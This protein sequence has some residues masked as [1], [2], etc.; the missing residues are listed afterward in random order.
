MTTMLLFYILHKNFPNTICIVT[1]QSFRTTINV[2][3]LPHKLIWNY[4]RI[5]KDTKLWSTNIGLYDAYAT[6]HEN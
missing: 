2:V 3:F 5:T 1:P 6:F 4:E